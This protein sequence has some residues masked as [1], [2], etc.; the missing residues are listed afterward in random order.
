MTS[1]SNAD[2]FSPPT[3]QNAAKPEQL[4]KSFGVK[5]QALRVLIRHDF[6][7][8]ITNLGASKDI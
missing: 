1:N 3:Y 5:E 8:M 7:S 2:F 6:S 4:G